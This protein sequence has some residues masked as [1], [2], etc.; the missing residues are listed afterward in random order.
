MSAPILEIIETPT[1]KDYKI[2]H[3]VQA[4]GHLVVWA[5]FSKAEANR[6]ERAILLVLQE[7]EKIQNVSK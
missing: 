7:Q 6:V 1:S 2:W 4:F 5:G 3:T